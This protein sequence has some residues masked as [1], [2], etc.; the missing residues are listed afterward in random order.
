MQK[1]K[2]FI[3]I[4]MIMVILLT[5]FASA[6]ISVSKEVVR[7]QVKIN[8]N[9]EFLLTITN[10]YAYKEKFILSFDIYSEWQAWTQPSSDLISGINL[11]PGESKTTRVIIHPPDNIRARPEFEILYSIKSYITG[12]LM[13][14]TFRVN[15][16]TE[17]GILPTYISSDAF[18]PDTVNP[19][20]E[21]I[22]KVRVANHNPQ[23]EENVKI[24]VKSELINEEKIVTLGK[25]LS[26]NET[27]T[28]EF[29]IQLDRFQ[30]PKLETIKITISQ[31]GE[32]LKEFE[33]RFEIISYFKLEQESETVKSFLKTQ[34]TITLTNKGNIEKEQ[35]VKIEKSFG[36]SFFTS[37]NPK[38]KVVK[39]EGKKYYSWSIELEVE[40][41]TTIQLTTSYMWIFILLLIVVVFVII[42]YAFK[43]PL[44]V[45]KKARKIGK[46][47]EGISELKVTIIVKNKLNKPLKDVLIVDKVP[48]IGEITKYHSIG[49]TAPSKVLKHA[50]KGSMINW[51]INTLEPKEERIL[52]YNIKSKLSI[53][54]EFVLPQTAAKYKEGSGR[55]YTT[56]SNKISIL[57]D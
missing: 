3:L 24:T 41:S 16:L 50:R 31:D 14:D 33:E 29:K 42:N 5:S 20:E 15:V 55:Q 2:R 11:E 9:A 44:V 27:H 56:R 21:F 30:E 53:L 35:I 18:L 57:E 23:I 38:A 19:K 34:R 51:K 47:G 46:K 48:D 22:L 1:Q 7:D 8:E 40:E 13:D 36:D 28:E 32:I 37:T 52:S 4:S 39:E 6:T 26:G 45:I 43:S 25:V 49:T 12:E 17:V 10:N 54:G